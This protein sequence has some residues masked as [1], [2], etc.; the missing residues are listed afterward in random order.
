MF[1]YKV[2]KNK[3]KSKS[4]REFLGD[5]AK[6][7]ILGAA[8]AGLVLSSCSSGRTRYEAP[9][10]YDRA[11]DGPLL[12]A[13]LIGCGGR[14]TGAAL[15][16]LSSGPN[17]KVTAIGDIFQHRIDNCRKTL[18][19]RADNDISDQN[20]FVG[21]D[22]YKKVIDSDVD[23]ILQV[24]PQ[25]FRPQHFEAAVQ[26]RK[27][28]FIEKPGG[29]D[30]V[31]VRTLMAAGKMAESAGLVVVAGTNFRHQ[32]DYLTTHSVVKSGI[33]GDLVSANAYDVRGK[34]WH[35]NRQ[36]GWSD[37][38]SML[39]D[40]MNW[41]WL[42]GGDNVDIAV[43]QIDM[44]SMFFDKFPVKAL[45]FGGRHRRPTGDV[46]DFYSVEY[47]FDDGKTFN[48]KTRCIDGCHNQHGFLIYGTKGYTNCQ[49]KIWDYNDNLIW[50]YEY[51]LDEEGRPTDRVAISSYVEEHINFV[52][53]IRNNTPMNQAEKL[54][55]ATLVGVMGRESAITGR[56]VT[57]DEMMTSNLRLG[58]QEYAMGPIAGI[59]AVP[60]VP[61]TAPDIGR[62]RGA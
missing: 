13:G 17:L 43:H 19:E 62:S 14:G 29:V 58:P 4:R 11:P 51:P 2:M 35:V 31:G 20:C 1:N 21:F 28:V 38:E 50:E 24:T 39:R 48:C 33:I 60:P 8:G 53:A 30:P 54:A 26:A 57:W 25:H 7:G 27:H 18:K 47:Q 44:I 61:G 40:W 5:A 59:E 41:Y 49:N 32:R 42:S 56:E 23:I 12:K 3:L 22:A 10:F 45:G 34:I 16:F 6:L 37:M 9:V 46:Y 36:D 52:T 15:N 55:A